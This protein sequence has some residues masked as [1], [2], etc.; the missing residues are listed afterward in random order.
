MASQQQR[1]RSVR[2]RISPTGLTVILVDDG[3]AT[4]STMI[5]AV[6]ATAL[7]QPACLVVAVPVSPPETARQIGLMEQVTE[8]VCLDTPRDFQGV[9]QFYRDFTQVEDETVIKILKEFA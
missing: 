9:G 7:A 2:P 3:L 6:Q 8:F 5:A 1:Y 4:G